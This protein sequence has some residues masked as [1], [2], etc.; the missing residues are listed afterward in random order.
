MKIKRILS[1]TLTLMVLFIIGGCDKEKENTSKAVASKPTT[2]SWKIISQIQT[3]YPNNSG[4]FLDKK[5]G[6]TV[7]YSGEIH[8]TKDG[9]KSWETGVNSSLCLFGI[10]MINDKTAW[11]CGNGAY[12][13]KTTNGGSSWRMVGSFGEYEPNQP[14]Y[15][16]FIN[17]NTGWVATPSEFELNGKRIRLAYT[18]DG[19]ES[20]NAIELP[21]DAAAISAIYLRDQNNGYVL[22]KEGNLYAT[23][24]GGKNFNKQPLGLK[25]ID[26]YV[27]DVPKIALKFLDDKNALLCYHSK[28]GKLQA[29]R[30]KNSGVTWVKETMP[31]IYAGS[32]SISK[33]GNIL[34]S[35]SGDGS[36]K[37]L[38]YE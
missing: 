28:D 33:D 29:S 13:V 5:T 1:V 7:G 16:S 24:D 23:K 6:I 17:E 22:D 25:D 9:G 12:V 4:Y 37:V 35:T 38:S 32:L 30:S 18:N 8:F 11:A 20:W 19:G 2:P 15:I 21:K 34:T 10:C 3:G 36:I 14:R 26:Y 27:E 31:D